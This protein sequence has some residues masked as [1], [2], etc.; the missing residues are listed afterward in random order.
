MIQNADG[1][2]Q[3]RIVAEGGRA[4][5]TAGSRTASRLQGPID[6]SDLSNLHKLLF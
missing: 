6:E 2:G 5:G 3:P 1:S 4:E